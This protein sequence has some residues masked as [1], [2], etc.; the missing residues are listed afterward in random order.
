MIEKNGPDNYSLICD[1]CGFEDDTFEDFNEA[2]EYKKSSN[3]K[4]YKSIKGVWHDVCFVC[5]KE[6][7]RKII[8]KKKRLV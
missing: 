5:A 8:D 2:V 6:D 3:W 1:I 7:Y 4:C